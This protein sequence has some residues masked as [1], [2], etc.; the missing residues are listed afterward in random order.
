MNNLV[1]ELCLGSSCFAR[2][3]AKAL[4][5]LES[6][7][8]EHGLAS[9]VELAGH[10]CLGSCSQGPNIKIGGV[11]HSAVKPDQVIPLV[12]EAL[13]RMEEAGRGER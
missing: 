13:E 6:Y 4:A 8:E 2:G 12:R 10:L 11:L 9:R 3:N 7:I 1:V 5:I